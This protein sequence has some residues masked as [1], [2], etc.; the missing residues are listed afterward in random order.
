MMEEA[1][2]KAYRDLADHTLN[3]CLNVCGESYKCKW[4]NKNWKWNCCEQIYCEM[5]R[6]HAKEHWNIDLKDTEDYIQGRT[7]L[8]MMTEK[9]CSVEPHLRPC[10]T[11]HVCVI[12]SIGAKI[13]DPEWTE[14][15]FELR[16]KIED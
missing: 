3:E 14:K 12:N 13:G 4:I 11:L 15:Y 8:P 10:C 5:A 2:K 16:K 6:S 1:L 7:P 9:G